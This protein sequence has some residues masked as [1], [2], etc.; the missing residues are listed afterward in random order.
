M[1]SFKKKKVKL[2]TVFSFDPQSDKQ[3]PEGTVVERL[4]QIQD[5]EPG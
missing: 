2:L 5:A 4:S 1:I 3:Q